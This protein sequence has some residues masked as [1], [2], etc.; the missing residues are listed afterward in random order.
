VIVINLPVLI[1]VIIW[2]CALYFIGLAS[3]ITGF[4]EIKAFC[5]NMNG[6][7]AVIIAAICYV[8]FVFVISIAIL[9]TVS[10]G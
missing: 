9:L 7:L 4:S 2:K 8:S 3:D 1:K 5:E 6:V 10:K